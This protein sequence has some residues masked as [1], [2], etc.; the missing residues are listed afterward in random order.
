VGAIAQQHLLCLRSL[1]GVTTVAVCDRSRGVAE[2]VAE[3]HGVPAAY[4]DHHELLDA[5][6]PDVV[7]VTTPVTSH[8][9][10]ATAALEAGADVLVEKPIT[11]SYEDTR[12]LLA[13]A[14][15]SGRK[16]LENY[17][18]VFNPEVQDVLR[19]ART[20]EL[21]EVRHVEVELA[22]DLAAPDS[23]FAQPGSLHPSASMPGGAIADFLPHIASL[24]HAFVGQH[25]GVRSHWAQRPGSPLAADEL[26]ALIS[27]ERGSAVISFSALEQ[28]DVFRLRV[29]GTR[30]RAHVNLFEPRLVLERLRDVPGPLV[31]LLN[32][33]HESRAAGAA[34]LGGLWNKL[35]SRPTAYAGLW[36][37]IART[38]EAVGNGGE[39]PVSPAQIDGVNKLVADLT[40]DE[41]RM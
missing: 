8:L 37:L 10:I 21:G 26:R 31:H 9:A 20:H 3:R 4:T 24:V 29:H 35:A 1:P 14:E 16:V 18:Y 25:R 32:G 13:T 6:K 19:R 36:A 15:R 39:A 30:M 5:A 7:H 2:A 17:N 11:T 12:A 23:V 27:A 28:P 22:L 40:R 41:H 33:L 38:Y 34:A